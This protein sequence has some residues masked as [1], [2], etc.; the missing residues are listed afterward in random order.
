MFYFRICPGRYLAFSSVWLTA[1]SILTTMEISNWV[2]P[3]T[4]EVDIP[5]GEYVK[6]F[7]LCTFNAFLRSGLLIM[8]IFRYP[9]P[10]KCSIKPRY[11]EAEELIK[12]LET[13]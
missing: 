8:L 5:N 4:G 2:D 9:K 6:G 13:A 3:K 7:G 10:F 12:S 11:K 1:S